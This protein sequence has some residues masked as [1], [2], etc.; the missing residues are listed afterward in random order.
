MFVEPDWT[1][2]IDFEA[3]LAAVPE[4]AQVRGMF[5]QL[6]L[7]AVHPDARAALGPRRY[8]AFKTYP[9]RDYIELLQLCCANTPGVANAEC[10]RRL[11]RRVYPTYA[12]TVTGTAIFAVAGSSY[13]RVLELCPAA[14]RIAIDP[15]TITVKTISDTH[16]E[17][18]LR[19]VYNIPDF[20]Q[21]GIFE[22]AMEVC[23][24]RGSIRVRQHDLGSVDFD[25]RWTAPPR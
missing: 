9:M 7:Q 22:G 2:P 4:G 16:A 24:A 12:D 19:D 18:E 10:V 14:Y 17:I 6:L 3:R 1:S 15:G 25:I 20:H 13:Q 21:V 5:L 8:I 23:R 11:G